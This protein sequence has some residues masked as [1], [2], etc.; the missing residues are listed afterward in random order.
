MKEQNWEGVKVTISCYTSLGL[1][2]HERSQRTD[3]DLRQGIKNKLPRCHWKESFNRKSSTRPL[4]QL[5]ISSFLVM[6]LMHLHLPVNS[7]SIL[8][9][10]N[11]IG[12]YKISHKVLRNPNSP[13]ASL[14]STNH[15]YSTRCIFGFPKSI[16]FIMDKVGFMRV[17]IWTILAHVT[18]FTTSVAN[19]IFVLS[20]ACISMLFLY[21]LAYGF[22]AWIGS[23]LHFA[24]LWIPWVYSV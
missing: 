8:R 2:R 14:R 15:S 10:P 18:L 23:F 5:S 16:Q 19:A 24:A 20:R 3:S 6:C 17:T 7:A 21:L 9:Y 12:S 1:M 22:W 13:Y 11:L 4:H